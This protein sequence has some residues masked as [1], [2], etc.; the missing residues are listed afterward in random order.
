MQKLNLLTKIQTKKLMFD[1]LNKS[2]LT[3]YANFIKNRSWSKQGGCLFFLEEGF[4]TIPGMI[5][6]KIAMLTLKKFQ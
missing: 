5:N 3:L 6:Y 2:H 1:P 4:E